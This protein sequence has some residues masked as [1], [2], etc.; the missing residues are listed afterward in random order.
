MQN[1]S[2]T[3]LP[4][5]DFI[6]IDFSAMGLQ[7]SMFRLQIHHNLQYLSHA[8]TREI[9]GDVI[10]DILF[11]HFEPFVKEAWEKQTFDA[12]HS[13]TPDAKNKML[14]S[15]MQN[16]RKTVRHMKTQTNTSTSLAGTVTLIP[17]DEDIEVKMTQR[18]FE[19]LVRNYLEQWV[20]S[21]LETAIKQAQEKINSLNLHYVRWTGGSS[22][23]PLFQ[24]IVKEY[25]RRQ[26]VFHL[27]QFS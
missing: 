22:Q 17:F 4:V 5:F 10:D 25:F 23:L 1:L 14:M 20:Q 3:V 6:I 13:N 2:G 18:E 7:A 26:G 27:F 8:S 15:T 11:K 16:L 21:T 19:S 9:S 12:Q 24:N